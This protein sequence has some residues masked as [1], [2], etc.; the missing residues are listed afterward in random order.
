[1]ATRAG[2]GFSEIPQSEDA[3]REAASAAMAEAGL[4]RCD[5]AL[6]LSGDVRLDTVI[7]HGCK[8]SSRYHTITQAEG[9][10]VL[11]IDGQPAVEAI[12]KL[13]G[14]DSYK[15]WEDYPFFVT[16]GVN[17]GECGTGP[18]GELRLGLCRRVDAGY[19]RDAISLAADFRLSLLEQT[20]S[21]PIDLSVEAGAGATAWLITQYYGV[22][23]S[24][25]MGKVTPVLGYRQVTGTTDDDEDSDEPGNDLGD[26]LIDLASQ[27][28]SHPAARLRREQETNGGP[29]KSSAGDSSEKA[30]TLVFACQLFPPLSR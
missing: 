3:G 24:H 1:M 18:V 16:L 15:S 17:K 22:Y 14:P 29:N 23:A 5:L 30:A 8:P 9:N 21:F 20:D 6:V 28:I 27:P 4:S 7:V 25:R 19:R 26:D 10:V 12:A 13:L 11:E 2:V